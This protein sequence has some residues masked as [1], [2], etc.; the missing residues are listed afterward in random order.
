[1]A[2]IAL[3]EL[4]LIH[5]WL[6]GSDGKDWGR[7]LSTCEPMPNAIGTRTDEQL[8]GLWQAGDPAAFSILYSRFADRLFRFVA[9]MVNSR[10]EAEEVCQEA[11]LAV[12]EGRTRYQPSA[13]FVTYLFTIAHRRSIDRLRRSGRSPEVEVQTC[14][15]NSSPVEDGLQPERIA[16]TEQNASRLLAAINDL[17]ILQREAF[18]MQAEG[19]LSLEE[20]AIATN[21]AREAVKSRLRYAVRRL[22]AAL[23]DHR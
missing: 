1:M 22:R 11:W 9:R 14:D 6:R 15:V 23:Q 5:G 18:L 20:I 2:T 3:M 21:S 16:H 7:Y 19:E 17:P 10:A 13:R 8:M 4:T 12:I